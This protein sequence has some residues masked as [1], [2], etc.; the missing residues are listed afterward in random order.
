[1][2]NIKPLSCL[3]RICHIKN[4]GCGIIKHIKQGLQKYCETAYS[5]SRINQMWIL[6]FKGVIRTS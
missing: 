5:R 3:A 4:I 2:T 6:E 1:M